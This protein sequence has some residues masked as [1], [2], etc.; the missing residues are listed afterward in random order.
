MVKIK[1]KNIPAVL[2]LL[3]LLAIV[4]FII[5]LISTKNIWI[6]SF[7]AIAVASTFFYTY[8]GE[9]IF[10]WHADPNVKTIK[11]AMAP[12]KKPG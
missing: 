9:A 7:L 8:F 1:T 4:V 10:D 12:L 6:A 11:K 5:F 2:V 3:V